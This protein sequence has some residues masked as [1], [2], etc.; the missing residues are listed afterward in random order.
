MPNQVVWVTNWFQLSGFISFKVYSVYSQKHIRMDRLT[1]ADKREKN[2]TPHKGELNPNNQQR[3][4]QIYTFFCLAFPCMQFWP[5]LEK[6]ARTP[7]KKKKN[8][9]TQWTVTRTNNICGV[10]CLFSYHQ[11]LKF[12]CFLSLTKAHKQN[13]CIFTMFVFS[14][15]QSAWNQA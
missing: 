7:I 15:L 1:D 11:F 9:D 3:R 13:M 4:Y 8:K 12:L 14:Q 6:S 10:I 5:R 2:T